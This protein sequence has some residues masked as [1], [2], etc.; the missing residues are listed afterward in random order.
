MIGDVPPGYGGG[1]GDPDDP[2]RIETAEQFIAIAYRPADFDKS[3]ALTADLDFNDVDSNDVLPI[4]LEHLAFSG[5][6]DGRSHSL[7]NLSILRPDDRCVGVFGIVG[8]SNVF[9]RG[10]TIHY[11]INDNDDFGWGYGQ[12]RLPHRSVFRTDNDRPDPE[13]APAR[14]HSCRAGVRR[15]A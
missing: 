8:P 14:C 9:P 13:S 10:Q 15:A 5:E 6:F 12:S 7:S 11:D 2:Y 1:S 3:F 4:G